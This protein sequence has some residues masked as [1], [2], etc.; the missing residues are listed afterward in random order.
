[1]FGQKV[2]G[3]QKH[4]KYSEKKMITKITTRIKW[5]CLIFFVGFVSVSS[6]ALA[7]NGS[8]AQTQASP[9][10]EGIVYDPP[11]DP[12][13]VLTKDPQYEV[14]E[15]TR[16]YTVSYFSMKDGV[17]HRQQ[18]VIGGKLQVRHK[19]TGDIILSVWE[20]VAPSHDQSSQLPISLPTGKTTQ[21]V[22]R[23][24]KSLEK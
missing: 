10:N 1:L 22:T 13:S 7:Q 3:Q 12:V 19:E 14:L 9:D 16:V 18:A 15:D 23:L 5:V 2:F 17:P 11:I 6:Q 20:T 8:S 4:Q 21:K 24:E